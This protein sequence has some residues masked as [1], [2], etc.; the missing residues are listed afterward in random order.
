V[1]TIEEITFFIKRSLIN[2]R[3]QH[4]DH[5]QEFTVMLNPGES[6]VLEA[7]QAFQEKLDDSL[8]FRY[9]CRFK[10]CG[11]CGVTINGNPRMACMTKIKSNM[12]LSPLEHIPVHQDLV[13]KRKFITEMIKTKKLLPQKLNLA[14]HMITS[15]E[16]DTLSKCTDCQSCLSGC[17]KYS[18]EN[19]IHLQVL[20][21]LLN[22]PNCKNI[23]EMSTIFLERQKNWVLRNVEAV[24]GARAHMG[25]R[26][27]NW[28]SI[29][30]LRK[31]W[32]E[33][34]K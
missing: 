14:K 16:F 20:C 25:S 29:Y 23:R 34:W 8:A 9:G 15:K 10:Q 11:L 19:R 5:I 22:L 18:Y 6:T 2:P 3:E 1:K 27:K 28:L 30:F 4:S 21:L 31:K 17:P 32:I 24:P 26:L 33:R 12:V 13:V 7:L